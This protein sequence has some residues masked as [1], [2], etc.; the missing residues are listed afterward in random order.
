MLDRRKNLGFNDA[1]YSKNLFD[2]F[3]LWPLSRMKKLMYE[4]A[5]HNFLNFI[6]ENIWIR[7]RSRDQL[8]D[9]LIDPAVEFVVNVEVVVY[10]N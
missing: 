10:K 7:H 1:V 2:F 3:G 8:C 9:V 4:D 5:Q 6:L